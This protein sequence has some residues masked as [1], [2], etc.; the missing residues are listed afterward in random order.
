MPLTERDYDLL[1]LYIDDALTPPER[2]A[3]E[4]RLASDA[5]FRAELDALRQT[6]ALVKSLPEMVAPR[7]L[8]LTPKMAAAVMAELKAAQPTAKKRSSIVYR[9]TTFAAAAASLV[10]VLAGALTLLQPQMQTGT[11]ATVAVADVMLV[12]ETPTG[13]LPSRTKTDET[14][15]STGVI[16]LDGTL[17]P[18]ATGGFGGGADDPAN[19]TLMHAEP[20]ATLEND[21]FSAMPAPVVAPED[22]PPGILQE[23]AEAPGDAADAAFMTA[24][25]ATAAATATLVF[26]GAVE[27]METSATED[28]DS[29]SRTFALPPGTPTAAGTP[30]P[31]DTEVLEM[32]GM[33]AEPTMTLEPAAEVIETVVADVEDD[34]DAQADTRDLTEAAPITETSSPLLGILLIIMGLSLGVVALVM[35][36]RGG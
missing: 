24:P 32:A 6:I 9:L 10:L 13:T 26:P 3:V 34:R 35:V 28:I 23:E 18:Y 25:S 5:E 22:A 30:A 16:I 1:S 21:P 14:A 12:T 20:I 7:D 31:T 4:S 29:A 11:S 27:N 19:T 15:T 33:A 17:M 36:L 8:R 2:R